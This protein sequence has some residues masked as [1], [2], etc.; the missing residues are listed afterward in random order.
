MTTITYTSREEIEVH[1]FSAL[2]TV[3]IPLLAIFFQVYVSS[4]L[5]FLK[6]FDIPLLVTISLRYRVV[7]NSLE[8]LPAARLGLRRMR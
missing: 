5:G 4:R 2:A 8:C 6:L 1:K 3:G 7:T